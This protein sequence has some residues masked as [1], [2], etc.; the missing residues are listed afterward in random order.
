MADLSKV[1]VGGSTYNLKDAT[2][3]TLIE[4]IQNSISKGMTLLGELDHALT[5]AGNLAD[6]SDLCSLNAYIKTGDSTAVCY[7]TGTKPTATTLSDGNTTF[8]ITY[9]Q[10]K[11]GD[12]VLDHSSG[13]ATSSDE[14]VFVG[15]DNKWHLLGSPQSVSAS[16]TPEGTVQTT[17]NKTTKTLSHTVT[18]GTVSASGKATPTGTVAQGTKTTGS[19]V[20]S[21]PGATSKMDQVTV[22]DTPTLK[23]ASAVTEDIIKY[24]LTTQKMVT[25]TI[26][27]VGGTMTIKAPSVASS[28]TMEA[29]VS[30]ET[31]VLSA[32]TLAFT[33]KTVA[34][35][36]ASNTTVATGSLS[37]TGSGASV[38]TELEESTDGKYIKGFATD[39]GTEFTSVGVDM[40]AGSSITVAKGTVSANGTGAS[41][42]TGLGTPTKGNA[43]TDVGTPTFTGKEQ[44]ITVSGNTTG[45]AV[46]SHSID[47][48]DSATSKFT[49]TQKTITSA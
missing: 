14:Y 43:L 16:Y 37:S 35:A 45:V 10:L 47:T 2:A 36:A 34:T 23:K 7:Y 33:D 12:F 17:L 49:G 21:Y 4:N 5:K 39:D 26:K 48:P 11:T 29:S 46:A 18:Q 25:T 42:M 24:G 32:G 19:F 30:G 20:Q 1:T 22:H 15:T 13:S 8:T 40:S 44:T 3:R 41:V 6:F 31:L 9:V 27:G 28:P 38:G